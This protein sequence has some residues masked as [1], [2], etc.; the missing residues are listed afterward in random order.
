MI[1]HADGTAELAGTQGWELRELKSSDIV[2]SHAQ[3]KKLLG[4]SQRFSGSVGE[5]PRYAEGKN[6]TQEAFDNELAAL[7]H[8]KDIEHWTTAEF[9]R[10]YDALYARYRGQLQTDQVRAYEKSLADYKHDIAEADIDTLVD[11]IVNT[12]DTKKALDRIKK[13]QD[14]KEISADETKK[15]RKEV[16]QN[17][18]KYTV[19]EYEAGRKS[20][21]DMLKVAKDYWAEVGKDT[22]EYY[23]SLDDMR[24]ASTKKLSEQT[25]ADEDRMS[26]TQK[27][28]QLQ[29]S[30]LKRQQDINEATK[31]EV[32]DAEELV[33]L[34]NN[35]AQAKSNMVRVY[36]EGVG[37]VY[38][39]NTKEVIEAQKA[40]DEYLEEHAV[41][42]LQEQI[43]AYQEIL[44]L[45][46]KL[47]DE[48]DIVALGK[49][50]GISGIADL[51]GGNLLNKEFMA[52]W[53][54]TNYAEIN[55]LEDLEAQFDKMTPEMFEQYVE[56]GVTNGMI[57][58]RQAEYAYNPR[59][60]YDPGVIGGG[61]T[62]G[63]T[64]Y[65]AMS[66]GYSPRDLSS[67]TSNNSAA[68]YNYSFDKLVLPNV[69]NANDFIAELNKLPNRAIQVSARRV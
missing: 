6:A 34:Q 55:A 8:R 24:E 49:K 1:V 64:P 23:D 40:L 52:D 65:S 46:D 69:S 25:Q 26:Y 20:Y 63:T 14:A 43:D 58:A 21:E 27:Y 37:F 47:E 48:A 68:S 62:F 60:I 2:Y 67:M 56:T 4:G 44:D 36:K 9:Q 35:L 22:K 16:Y 15:L 31:Q 17:A 7:Q 51:V 10:Q 13:A 32:K 38:E 50:L 54:K 3:T 39:Q 57:K 59:D 18:L 5:L 45:F 41:D 42:P 12:G 61:A 19:A 33:E 29:I 28:I 53:I 66:T 30:E 11:A